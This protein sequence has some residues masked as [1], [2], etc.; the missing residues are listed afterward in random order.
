MGLIDSLPA[1]PIAIDTQIIIY[2][3]QRHPDFVDVIRPLFEAA[4]QGSVEVVTSSLT[5]LE[6]LV[7]PYREGDMSLAA[8]YEALLTGSRGLTIVEL[9]TP[10]LRAAALLRALHGTRTPDAIQL[11]SALA[12]G[13]GAFV[14]NDRRLRS[15]PNLQV[16]QL[17]D[18]V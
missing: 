7:L 8:R 9:G 11:A 17:R 3:I 6:V 15:L 2:F 1:G 14:T 10:V 18:F 12:R 5:L 16:V 13:C 4:D